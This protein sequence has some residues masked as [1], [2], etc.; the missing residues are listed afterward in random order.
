[1]SVAAGI[2]EFVKGS[3]W[4][5]VL[6]FVMGD[7]GCL[8]RRDRRQEKEKGT[9]HS[10]ESITN[11]PATPSTCCIPHS[12]HADFVDA[13]GMGHQLCGPDALGRAVDYLDN[14]ERN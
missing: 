7:R 4:S 14:S 2:G 10:A 3:V 12:F 9:L 6:K 1:M 13:P 5:R 8:E 11:R